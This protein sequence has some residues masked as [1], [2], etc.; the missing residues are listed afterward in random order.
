MDGRAAEI[1]ANPDVIASYL[2]VRTAAA[3]DAH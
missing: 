3:A 1:S 2:G